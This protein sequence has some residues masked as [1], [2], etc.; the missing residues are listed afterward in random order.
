MSS[1][2]QAFL[3]LMEKK[4]NMIHPKLLKFITNMETNFPTIPNHKNTILSM[5]SLYM[6]GTPEGDLPQSLQLI[7]NSN[8]PGMDNLDETPLTPFFNKFVTDNPQKESFI[9]MYQI[10]NHGKGKCQVTTKKNVEKKKIHKE[11]PPPPVNSDGSSSSSSASSSSSVSSSTQ[12]SSASRS[13]ESSLFAKEKKQSG[14]K[15]RPSFK[16][17]VVAIGALKNPRTGGSNQTS[18][19]SV[20]NPDGPPE[21]FAKRFASSK[22][23]TV[24]DSALENIVAKSVEMNQVK[25]GAK[26]LKLRIPCYNGIPEEKKD[27]IQTLRSMIN[28]ENI[29]VQNKPMMKRRSNRAKE[30]KNARES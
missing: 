22:N 11:T 18:Q 7:A 4:E 10:L 5:Y 2:S 9:H 13:T 23:D 8:I 30:R 19:P 24:P 3:E 29:Y 21:E 28:F 26:T 6:G 12:S 15:I 25:G 1:I 17:K 27:I 16:R 20:S 14:V